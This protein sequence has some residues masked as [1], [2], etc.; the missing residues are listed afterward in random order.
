VGS[1]GCD[2]IREKQFGP[3]KSRVGL[4]RQWRLGRKQ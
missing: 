2:V 4:R 1:Q 3:R